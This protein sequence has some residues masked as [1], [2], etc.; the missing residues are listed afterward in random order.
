MA[1]VR[2]DRFRMMILM[3]VFNRIGKS[4]ENA[5]AREGINVYLSVKLM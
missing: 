4:L 3:I 5:D 2:G 1:L